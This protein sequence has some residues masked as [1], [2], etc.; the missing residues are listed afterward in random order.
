MEEYS[1]EVLKY[2]R[3]ADLHGKAVDVTVGRRNGVPAIF[4]RPEQV[5]SLAVDPQ[6]QDH[7]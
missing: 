6:A 1:P 5:D 2:Q 3:C 4:L 7:D